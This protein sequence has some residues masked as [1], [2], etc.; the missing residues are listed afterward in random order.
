M[1]EESNKSGIY[2]KY[3]ILHG[4]YTQHLNCGEPNMEPTNYAY[5][6]QFGAKE[7]RVAAMYG[8]FLYKYENMQTVWLAAKVPYIRLNSVTFEINISW[9][10]MTFECCPRI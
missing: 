6:V 4:S 5:T 1:C 2:G 9:P 7:C 3:S 10:K 8:N